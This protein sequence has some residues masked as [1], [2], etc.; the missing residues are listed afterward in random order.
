MV[1]RDASLRFTSVL[2]NSD[3]NAHPSAK[4]LESLVLG[5]LKRPDAGVVVR[6]LLSGCPQCAQTTARLWDLE[7][8]GAGRARKASL[9]EASRLS[10]DLEGM[11]E[12]EAAAHVEVLKLTVE[13]EAIRRKA[14]ALSDGLPAPPAEEL[15][16]EIRSVIRSVVQDMIEPAIRSLQGGAEYRATL[17]QGEPGASGILMDKN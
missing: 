17:H 2:R 15:S 13:L 10:S 1:N 9:A 4:T 16:T 3:V 14:L 7:R 12:A 11:G 6:H 8:P 5:K